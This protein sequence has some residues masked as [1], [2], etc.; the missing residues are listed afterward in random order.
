MPVV[1]AA[2]AS[3]PDQGPP[4]P[5]RPAGHDREAVSAA[6]LAEEIGRLATEVTA[7]QLSATE[8]SVAELAAAVERLGRMVRTARDTA[9]DDEE[10]YGGPV[11]E[12]ARVAPTAVTAGGLPCD[13]L[14]FAA[15]T[16]PHRRAVRAHCYRMTGSWDD[17]EDLVRETFLRAWRARDTFTGGEL[18]AW[19]YRMAT[20]ACLDLQRRTAR[21]P[22]AYDALPGFGRG[23]GEAPT[24]VAWLQPYPDAELPPDDGAFEVGDGGEATG[25]G[26]VPRG[27]LGLAAVVALQQ[28]PPRQRAALLLR[29]VLALSPARTAEA[30]DMTPD[31]LESALLRARP[32]LRALLPDGVPGPASGGDAVLARYT[33]AAEAGDL[34]ALGGL[35]A[36]DV[37]LTA[38]PNRWWCAGREAVLAFLRPALD[39]AS[40]AYPG[41][42]LHRPTRANGRPA[43]GI[44][45]RRTGTAV[46][47]AEAFVVLSVA[48]DRVTR[49][50]SFEP[51]LLPAF[52]LPPRL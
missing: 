34:A 19:L 44:Y 3:C 30:L 38:P 32:A 25:E 31:A 23:S 46:H 1:S 16:E 21:R 27:P 17:A 18:G 50:T 28:L 26:V 5:D 48:D 43:A 24:R 10:E 8:P 11:P 7:R 41:H 29:D 45:V 35:L 13:G 52:G 15:L 39:P 42:R 37:L 9:A 40:P 12:A 4:P 14:A 22:H 2:A 47:R 36:E 33:A 51:H 6:R 49:I 20:A